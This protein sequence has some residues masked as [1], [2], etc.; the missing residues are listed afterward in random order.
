MVPGSARNW[1]PV[2]AVQQSS[3]N[4]QNNEYE[5]FGNFARRFPYLV[6]EYGFNRRGNT[7]QRGKI[8]TKN[9]TTLHLRK[10]IGRSPSQRG[11]FLI[12]LALACFALSPTAQ[13]ATPAPD[14]GYPSNSEKKINQ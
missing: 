1:I 5:N 11:F 13:G 4:Y 10:S 7:E 9:M 2:N 6:D 8:E 12:P 3:L 14:G